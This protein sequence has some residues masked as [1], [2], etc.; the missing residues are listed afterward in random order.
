MKQVRTTIL[1][2]MVL[3]CFGS[4]SVR[5]G[6]YTF[7]YQKIVDT[8]QQPISLDLSMVSG[9][10]TITG[11]SDDGRVTID[12]VKTVRGSHREEA[13]EVADHIE[14][15]VTSDNNSVKIE[16]NYLKMIDRK[17]SFWS[18]IFGTSSNNS[19][20]MVDYH[21]SVPSRTSVTIN[22]MEALIELSS[23]EGEMN[24]TNSSGAT[25]GEYLFGPITISQ[26]VGEVDLKWIE[27]DVRV[28][29]TS[30]R[31]S[32]QQTRGAVDVA[33]YSGSVKVQTQLDS[34]KNYYVET[35]SGS[36]DFT[37][38]TYSAGVLHIETKSGEI[39]SDIPIA[40]KSVSRRR[41]VGEFGGGGPTISIY[42]TTGDVDIKQ[43]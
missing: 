16:T 4:F 43:F 9:N 34:P 14:I 20:G 22:S 39:K 24:I 6:E 31:I 25:H 42:S 15:H 28:K 30:S 29:S 33:T 2:M 37:V 10:V 13:E 23:L 26:P 32:I 5:A 21:I 3:L 12:A 41:L 19:Y 1:L 17:P 27:G 18:K 36:V 7:Q 40:I 11:N 8:K 38:P 35:M